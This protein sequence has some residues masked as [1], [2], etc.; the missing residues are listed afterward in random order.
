MQVHQI[1]K[2]K[3]AGVVTV[4]PTMTVAEVSALMSSRRIGAVV[5]SA[6]GKAALGILSERDIVRELGNHGDGCL[7]AKV[8]DIMTPN[9][10]GCTR[11][12]TADQLMEVMTN[13]R[14]RHLPVIEDG[15]LVGMIS[16]GDVVKARLS[17]LAMEK[18]ALTGMIMGN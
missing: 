17:E 15:V 10:V 3:S 1:L 16:I 4:P 6:D 11:S 5:V 7:I 2:T 14:F 13:R 12:D 18:E 9:P 8:S